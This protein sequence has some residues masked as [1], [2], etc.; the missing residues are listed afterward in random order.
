MV[1]V[2]SWHDLMRIAEQIPESMPIM[3]K[4]GVGLLVIPQKPW[5]VVK[6]DFETYSE[7]F[8]EANGT[9]PPPF[10][11]GCFYVDDSRHLP[12]LHV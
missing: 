5:D 10:C 9:E 2:L 3:A 8:R 7:I 11:G 1:I 4:L 6:H 12:I